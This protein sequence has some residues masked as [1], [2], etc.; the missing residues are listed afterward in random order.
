ML[1][2]D[3]GVVNERRTSRLGIHITN[4]LA[5]RA[6]K[7]RVSLDPGGRGAP[8]LLLCHRCFNPRLGVPQLCLGGTGFEPGKRRKRFI[9]KYLKMLSFPYEPEGRRCYRLVPLI[10]STELEFNPQ[11]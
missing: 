11:K 8:S 3:L 2:G 10:R 1:R 7:L 6:L 4:P 9:Y 5:K